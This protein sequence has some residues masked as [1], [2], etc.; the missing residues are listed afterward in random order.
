MGEEAPLLEDVADAAPLLG[1][2]EP[3]L[4]VDQD[5]A[6]H[7][8]APA[9]GPDQAADDVDQRRLAGAGAAEQRRQPSAAGEPGL[10]RE[11]RADPVPDID[12]Q[13]HPAPSRLPIRRATSSEASSTAM[14]TKNGSASGRGGGDQ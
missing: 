5:F 12:L 9:I 8:D 11:A 4:G 10:Q 14:A 3:P 2:E 6:V 7:H 13:H 1:H